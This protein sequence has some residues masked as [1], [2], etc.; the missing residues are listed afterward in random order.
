MSARVPILMYHQVSPRPHPAFRKYTVA[1][2]A[3]AAQMAWLARAGYAT[4]TLDA[5]LAHRAGRGTLPPRPVVITFD[6]GFQECADHAT[7][8]LQAHGFE[9]IFYL[10]AGLAGSSS[11]WLGGELATEFPLLDWPTARRLELAGFQ[12]GAHSMSHPRLAE[13]SPAACREELQQS[14]RIL[15]DQLG[16]EVMDLAYPFGSFNVAVRT[17]AAETGYRSACSVRIGLSAADD[18]PLALHRVPVTGHDSLADFVCRMHT[19]RSVSELLRGG[20]GRVR[21]RLGFA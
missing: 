9:A 11:R 3:F 1:P 16:H 2:K 15:E 20:A 19:A 5:L 13:L 6:D 17:I 8:I 12:C 18:D 4:I 21:R 10:V 7:E 14:R